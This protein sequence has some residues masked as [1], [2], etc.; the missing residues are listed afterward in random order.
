M[1]FSGRGVEFREKPMTSKCL[2]LV[3][4]IAKGNETMN[5]KENTPFDR[6]LKKHSTSGP[7]KQLQ[8]KEKSEDR[9]STILTD[10]VFFDMHT[11]IN[12]IDI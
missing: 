3:A 2:V 7:S 5:I 10:T 12:I 4:I 9:N 1:E 6:G 8:G 11:V